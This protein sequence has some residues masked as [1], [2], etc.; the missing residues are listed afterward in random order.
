M[1]VGGPATL[2][3][4]SDP[5][6]TCSSGFGGECHHDADCGPNGYCSQNGVDACKCTHRCLTDADCGAGAICF[7]E[8]GA[9]GTCRPAYDCTSDA[10]CNGGLCAS[11]LQGCQHPFLCTRPGDACAGNHDC[12]PSGLPECLIPEGASAPVARTCGDFTGACGTGRPLAIADVVRVA[13]AVR[14]GDWALG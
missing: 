8:S 14:R 5:S 10:D 1:L 9:G 11:V 7:C 4:H 6:Y 13:R 2:P 3:P 12:P